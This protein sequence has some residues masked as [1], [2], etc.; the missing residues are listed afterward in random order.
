VSK[1]LT[2]VSAVTAGVNTVT[3]GNC[4]WGQHLTVVCEGGALSDLSGG[5]FTTGNTINV[6]PGFEDYFQFGL[7]PAGRNHRAIFRFND[8][9][10]A[11]SQ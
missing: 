10:N 7:W 8:Q 2:L 1:N 6:S 3:G 5:V 11:S 4:Y 9:R